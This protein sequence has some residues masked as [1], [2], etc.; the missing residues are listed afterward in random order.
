MSKIS[1]TGSLGSN[2]AAA[3]FP[4]VQA[5]YF[6]CV[7]GLSGLATNWRLAAELWSLPAIIGEV[8]YLCA[9]AIWIVFT[10]LFLTKWAIARDEA[11]AE[12]HNPVQS[13][14]VGLL[15]VSSMLIAL[16]V[17]PYSLLAGATLF[18]FGAIF[19]LLFAIWLTGSLWEGNRDPVSTTAALYLPAGAGSFVTAIA[20]GAFGHSDWSQL[21][22]GA[23][24]FSWLAI[25]SVVLHRLL[26]NKELPELLRP[27]LGIQLAPP[28]VGCLAYL[29]GTVGHPDPLSHALFGYGLLQLLILVRLIPWIRRK[30]LDLSYWGI[31]FGLTALTSASMKMAAR[32]DGP[33]LGFMAPVLLFVSSAVVLAIAIGS[34]RWLVKR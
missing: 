1:N 11:L 23:G 8:I 22:F 28:A 12:Y 14:F 3:H 18:A 26:T 5:S 24:F 6:G 19:T 9:G 29:S 17:Q 2:Y 33:V 21:A 20:A 15:G 27:M 7:L 16:G 4:R 10:L 13:C 31:T 34:I 32:T 30:S 25:E